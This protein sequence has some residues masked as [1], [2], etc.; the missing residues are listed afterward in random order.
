MS[1]KA[2]QIRDTFLA[3]ADLSAK[4]YHLMRMSDGKTINQ[5]SNAAGLHNIGV[6]QNKPAAA[7]RAAT[8]CLGGVSKVVAGAAI[9]APA[10][11]MSNGSGRAITATSGG[12]IVGLAKVDAAADGDVIAAVIFSPSIGVDAS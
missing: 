4:Q 5:A 7:G 2:S 3:A 8:L 1:Y 10:L 12:T 9:T 11:L 6:L